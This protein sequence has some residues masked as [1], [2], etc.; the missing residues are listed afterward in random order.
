M[1]EFFVAIGKKYDAPALYRNT[2]I[3]LRKYKMYEE[4]LSVIEAGL[5]NVPYNNRENEL[6]ERKE[7]VL[8]LINKKT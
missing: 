6:T 1:V 2:A 5:K 4:E 7:K 8:K 3:L